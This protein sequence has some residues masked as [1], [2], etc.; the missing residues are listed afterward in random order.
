MR[1][2]KLIKQLEQLVAT[3]GDLEVFGLHQTGF[4]WGVREEHV[5]VKSVQGWHG[6]EYRCETGIVID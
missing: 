2:T 4:F 1:A 3:N 6:G 5:K